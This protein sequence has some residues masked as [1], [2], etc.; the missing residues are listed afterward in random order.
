MDKPHGLADPAWQP[1]FHMFY[2]ERAVDMADNLP[3]WCGCAALPS[4]CV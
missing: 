2:S 4:T 3:K 1:H